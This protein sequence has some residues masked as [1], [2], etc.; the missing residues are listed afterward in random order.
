MYTSWDKLLQLLPTLPATQQITSLLPIDAGTIKHS[1]QWISSS[2]NDMLYLNPNFKVPEKGTS[3]LSEKGLVL[4]LI[5]GT[6]DFPDSFT[7]FILNILLKLPS[8]VYA[9]CNV[10][11]D[12]RFGGLSIQQQSTQIIRKIEANGHSDVGF[13]GHSRGG[14]NAQQVDALVAEKNEGNI[15][16]HFVINVCTPYEGS[17]LALPPL[18]SASTS[19]GQMAINSD[20]LKKVAK[21][22]MESQASYHFIVAR[23]DLVVKFD[24]CFV[25]EYVKK[26]P[27]SLTVIEREGHLGIM[28]NSYL[29]RRCLTIL[30]N[31]APSLE[32]KAELA[33]EPLVE[34]EFLASELTTHSCSQTL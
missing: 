13:V 28:H 23:D 12:N 16:V 4:Y 9:I 20:H 19:V 34:E 25:P 22:V 24:H 7:D 3:V 6:A 26:N 2:S 27:K 11:F 29:A 14:L 5:H 30:E 21:E 32:Q 10:T 1:L 33:N 15:K 17:Y 31:L 8:Y 18:R